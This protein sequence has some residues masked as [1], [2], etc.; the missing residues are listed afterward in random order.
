M[1][2]VKAK[3]V[4]TSTENDEK[5]VQVKK[6][7]CVQA[8]CSPYKLDWL[9]SLKQIFINVSYTFSQSYSDC[10]VLKTEPSE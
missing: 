3:G 10:S 6:Q 2:R 9:Q 8:R 1:D 4:A 5:H 7:G